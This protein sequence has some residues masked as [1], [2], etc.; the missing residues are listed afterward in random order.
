[1]TSTNATF[2]VDGTAS[3]IFLAAFDRHK[4]LT[5]RSSLIIFV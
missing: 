4:L 2:S 3:A 1:M 5:K